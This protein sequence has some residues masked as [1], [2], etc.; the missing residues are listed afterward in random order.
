M[1]IASC[2]RKGWEAH[3]WA[4][5]VL[6][7]GV[8]AVPALSGASAA[9]LVRATVQGTPWWGM[10]LGIAVGLPAAVA[11]DR[12]LRRLLPLGMLLRLSLEFPDRAPSRFAVALRAGMMRD[13]ADRMSYLHRH[14]APGD[15]SEA[16]SEIVTLLATLTR[17]HRR[18]RGHSERVRAFADLIAQELHLSAADRERLRWSSL[19]HDIGKLHLDTAIL[20]KPAGLDA[21]EWEA[22]RS[23]PHDGARIAAPLLPWLGEW[24]DAIA[25]HHERWDGDG[26]PHGTAGA[27]IPLAA[28]IVAVADSFEV[29]TAARPYRAV[30]VSV[31]DARRELLRC[32]GSQFDPD[33]VRAFLAVS[34]TRLRWLAG[35]A[36]VVAE[37]SAARRADA[38]VVRGARVAA[39]LAGSAA[40]VGAIVAAPAWG[41]SGGHPEASADPGAGGHAKVTASA[42]IAASGG[43]DPLYG[44]V[45]REGTDAIVVE[46]AT[47]APPAPAAPT[48][49]ATDDAAE[50]PNQ[51][52]GPLASDPVLVRHD[53]HAACATPPLV[54]LTVRGLSAIATDHSHDAEWR[55]HGLWVA[56]HAGCR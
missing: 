43:G 16:A 15:P 7:L 54:E 34:L 12:M 42:P 45:L 46:S 48:E 17:Y 33:I 13:V 25:Y 39:R 14:G 8:F 36:A 32:A 4:G 10:A 51:S 21:A 24:A 26:Y 22:V 1:H 37:L 53:A 31:P 5:R 55:T 28:R 3:P 30:A 11:T 47:A 44:A 50:P 23:H 29:M 9:A 35:P 38:A 19:L 52:E 27:A 40:I 20:D 41:P 56:A 2:H 49:A 18:T 6:D